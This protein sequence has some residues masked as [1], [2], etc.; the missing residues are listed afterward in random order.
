MKHEPMQLAFAGELWFWR[1]PA[2]WY[3][4][5][6]PDDDAGAIEA[7]S[8]RVSYGWGMVPVTARVGRTT[9]STSLW[10]KDGSYIVPI[11]A[12]VRRAERLELGDEVAIELTITG[13]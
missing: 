3:F 2:P 11:K 10:P 6:V 12:A 7:V 13:V 9:F 5:T 4:V 8:G 1:G